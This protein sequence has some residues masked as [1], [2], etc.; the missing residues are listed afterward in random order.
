MVHSAEVLLSSF[1]PAV[2]TVHAH[3]I[4]VGVTRAS[5]IGSDR[6]GK[7]FDEPRVWLQNGRRIE[8]VSC[9]GTFSFFPPLFYIFTTT[10]AAYLSVMRIVAAGQ[11]RVHQTT[12]ETLAFVLSRACPSLCLFLVGVSVD[13]SVT[14]LLRLS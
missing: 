12:H 10:R 3:G 5:F 11:R 7:W 2:V 14:I 6:V 8:S 1:C 4:R 9:R 13:G